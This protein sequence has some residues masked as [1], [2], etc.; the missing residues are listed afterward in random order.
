MTAGTFGPLSYIHLGPY[1]LPLTGLPLM[2]ARAAA[3]SPRVNPVVTSKLEGLVCHGRVRE[4]CGIAGRVIA[5]R[6]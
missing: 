1:L 5:R 6:G 2:L 3:Y 4:D